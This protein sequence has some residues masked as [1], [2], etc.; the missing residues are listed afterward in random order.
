MLHTLW[1]VVT[2][3]W[4]WFLVLWNILNHVSKSK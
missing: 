3:E 4:F 1:N 2:S